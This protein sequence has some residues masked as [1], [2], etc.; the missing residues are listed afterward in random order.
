MSMHPS[1]TLCKFFVLITLLM[2]TANPALAQDLEPRRWSHLPVGLNVLGVGVAN[3]RGDILL[4]P[5]LRIE[6]ASYR[7]DAIGLSY[8]RS[9][10]LFGR[11]ARFDAVAPLVDGRWEGLVDGEPAA[12][13][14]RGL[15]DPWLRFSINLYG[16]PA[17][18]GKEFMQYITQHETNT[19]VGAGIAIIAPLGEYNAERLINLGSNQWIFRPQLG[20][21]HQRRKWQFE[22][23]GSVFLYETNDE[24]F[25][26]SVL[27]K[28][29]LWFLQSHA[30]YTF[31]PSWWSSLSLGYAY[32]GESTINGVIKDDSARTS[33]IALS[34]GFNISRTQGLKIAYL[35]TRTNTSLGKDSD[36]LSLGWSFRWAGQ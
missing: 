8:V 35:R 7:L 6:D 21:L 33:L 23:T 25:K 28:D 17:L 2:S 9:F 11:S 16:A 12:V 10:G 22:L 4:D 31:N 1:I 14:R 18:K 5:V 30:I 36:T 32:G 15:A 27:E 24:F 3:A 19:N 29:P 13:D 26:N 34:L 20:V